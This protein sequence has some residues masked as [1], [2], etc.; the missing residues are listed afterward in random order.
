MVMP[1]YT[2]AS[3]AATGMLEVLAIKMVRFIRG[4]WLLGSSSSENS[5]RAWVISLPRSPQPR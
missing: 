3:R 1:V 4:C 2:D 5:S